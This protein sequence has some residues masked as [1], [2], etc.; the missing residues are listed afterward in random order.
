M[1]FYPRRDWTE[2]SAVPGCSQNHTRP[3]DAQGQLVHPWAVTCPA[4]EAYYKGAG[5]PKILKYIKDSKTG[6]ILRQERVP[7]VH[8]GVGFTPDTIPPTRDEEETRVL[9]LERGENQ[10]KALESIATLSKAGIDFRSRPDV[11]LFLR[12]NNL[13]DDIL[14]GSVLCPDG[15]QNAS[16]AKFCSKCGI[17]MAAKAVLPVAEPAKAAEPEEPEEAAVDL[18]LL[19]PQT[20]KKLCRTAGL[21]D[22]G[23]KEDLIGRLQ[24]A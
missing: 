11:L 17:S 3:A 1:T 15:H 12:E 10:L 13:P 19:H 16:D 18:A 14:Q 22:S 9:Q 23:S 8:P 7:D 24:A 4:H 2:I 5:K 21:A 20:L 6:A